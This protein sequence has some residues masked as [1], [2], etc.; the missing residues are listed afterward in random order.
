VQLKTIIEAVKEQVTPRA[1]VRQMDLIFDPLPELPLLWADESM[2]RR[3][4][5]NLIDNAIK[6]TPVHG[7]ITINAAREDE[8]L[9]L[10]VSDTGPGISP[11]D[12]ERIFNRFARIDSTA[13]TA[14]GV[15][16]GLAFCK[17]AV[18]A[19]SGTIS[20]ESEGVAGKGSTFHIFLPLEQPN[21][22]RSTA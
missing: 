17:L 2:L 12:Q 1:T 13:H 10:S 20:V 7:T 9:H 11:K 15:G 21:Y 16:L 18:E 14:S 4:L 22:S 19:H 8:T 6:Y 5:V 3:V